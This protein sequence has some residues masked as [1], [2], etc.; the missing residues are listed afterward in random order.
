[1][2][3]YNFSLFFWLYP[4][5]RKD[6]VSIEAVR[7]K[8]SLG[9]LLE[10]SASR[11]GL[12]TTSAFRQWL[13]NRVF[14]FRKFD[15]RAGNIWVYDFCDYRV[16]CFEQFDKVYSHFLPHFLSPNSIVFLNSQCRRHE[17]IYS[18]S[19]VSS[20]CLENSKI[21][22]KHNTHYEQLSGIP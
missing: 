22:S 21:T 9:P 12:Q 6:Q 18:T 14:S 5:E 8:S 16:I 4:K 13:S 3:H 17:L 10:K 19:C 2:L 1:M 20:S 15:N 11:L 7:R